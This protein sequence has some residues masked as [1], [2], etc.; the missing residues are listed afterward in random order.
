VAD[1]NTALIVLASVQGAFTV[2]LAVATGFYAV[3][4]HDISKAAKEQADASTEMAR[5]TR[6]QTS[7]T[8]QVVR[9]MREQT[10]ATMQTARAAQA[11]AD[12]ALAMAQ[13]MHEQ[14]FPRA[15]F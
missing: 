2:V 8:V 11:Q 10:S 4:T 14:S 6:E 9:E 7:A 15:N 3:R 12:A 13:V 1:A 5:E